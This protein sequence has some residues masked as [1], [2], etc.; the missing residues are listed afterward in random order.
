MAGSAGRMVDVT[1]GHPCQSLNGTAPMK[2]SSTSKKLFPEFHWGNLFKTVLEC[3]SNILVFYCVFTD[4]GVLCFVKQKLLTRLWSYHISWGYA[5]ILCTGFLCIYC[6]FE[7]YE[8]Q[9]TGP[10][11]LLSIS[12]LKVVVHHTRHREITRM[13]SSKSLLRRK[14]DS[15]RNTHQR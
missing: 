15:P 7:R 8:I 13:Y 5:C 4:T 12:R 6:L 9:R 10:R 1:R 3:S 14:A 2:N 11:R